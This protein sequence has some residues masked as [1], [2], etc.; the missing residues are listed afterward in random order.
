MTVIW[1]G[2]DRYAAVMEAAR[3]EYK[4]WLNRNKKEFTGV[5]PTSESVDDEDTFIEDINFDV[6]ES[7]EDLM[8][9]TL[10]SINQ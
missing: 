4:V 1:P 10:T 7:E 2:D 8:F 3:S 5:K 9:G 6:G